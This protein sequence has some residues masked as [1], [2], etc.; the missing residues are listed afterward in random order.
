MS[1]IYKIIIFLLVSESFF[2]QINNSEFSTAENYL[3]SI[4]KLFLI[5]FVADDYL[6]EQSVFIKES[7]IIDKNWGRRNLALNSI[8]FL[9]KNNDTI[10]Y[11]NK[12]LNFNEN[13]IGLFEI[14]NKINNS[15]FENPNIEKVNIL[16]SLINKIEGLSNLEEGTKLN[17]RKKQLNNLC[18]NYLLI[19]TIKLKNYLKTK[20]I[21]SE[22]D[23]TI[24][25]LKKLPVVN[26]NV[27]QPVAEPA[28][29]C[30]T[31]FQ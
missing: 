4:N 13:Q 2:G 18:K 1:K 22:I 17:E 14:K 20:F 28:P 29:F 7:D 24:D 12:G 3:K 25:E 9:S 21:K 11:C 31:I 6:K 26:E 15:N 10:S 30:G 8:K 19:S 27:G 23:T 5:D 16:K